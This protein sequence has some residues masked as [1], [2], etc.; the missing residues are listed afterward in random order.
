MGVPTRPV[1]IIVIAQNEFVGVRRTGLLPDG[2]RIPGRNETDLSTE[3]MNP[4]RNRWGASSRTMETARCEECG[5]TAT[6]TPRDDLNRAMIDHFL[7]MD[8][9]PIVRKTD[10]GETAERAI[11]TIER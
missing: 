6:E 3:L 1:V 10:G 2:R 9:S 11:R 5:W 7:E 4:Y 8:H